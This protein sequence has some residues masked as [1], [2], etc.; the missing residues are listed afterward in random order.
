MQSNYLDKIKLFYRIEN[1]LREKQ[2]IRMKISNKK[3]EIENGY[4][5]LFPLWVYNCSLL[6]SCFHIIMFFF[7]AWGDIL[8]EHYGLFLSVMLALAFI[9][10]LYQDKRGEDETG[11]LCFA[12]FPIT[13]FILFVILPFI[14]VISVFKILRIKTIKYKLNKTECSS[15]I[16][17]EIKKLIN[18]SNRIIKTL[19]EDYE[20][21]EYLKDSDNNREIKSKIESEIRNKYNNTSILNLHINTIKINTIMTE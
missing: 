8:G 5:P 9:S 7:F 1:S 10:A 2:E 4:N 19:S 15:E 6:I 21:L 14:I 11:L 12:I 17:D 18:E 13:T 16:D 3:D 20:A